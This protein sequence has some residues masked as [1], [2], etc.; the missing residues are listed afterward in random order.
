MPRAQSIDVG[1]VSLV[2]HLQPAEQAPDRNLA[3]DLVRVTEA[4][5]MAAGR[6]VGR[7]DK[8]GADGVAVHAMRT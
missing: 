6:W 1:R 4:G 8:N 5:A 3:L 2:D 7:G